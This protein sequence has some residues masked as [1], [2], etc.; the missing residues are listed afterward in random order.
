M[1]TNVYQCLSVVLGNFQHL[2]Q[3]FIEKD[4][5]FLLKVFKI[6][7]NIYSRV[8]LYPKSFFYILPYPLCLYIMTL[9]ESLFSDHSIVK[10]IFK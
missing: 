4:L 7:L 10:D 8:T 9:P 5:A 6:Y 2:S 3:G 1:P